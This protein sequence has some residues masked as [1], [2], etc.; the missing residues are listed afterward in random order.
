M[1]KLRKWSWTN[2]QKVRSHFIYYFLFLIFEIL[3]KPVSKYAAV[4]LPAEE[5]ANPVHSPKWIPDDENDDDD[6]LAYDIQEAPPQPKKLKK[7]NKP[8]KKKVKAEGE[9]RQPLMIISNQLIF[10]FEFY[11]LQRCPRT[12]RKM[13]P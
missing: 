12:V 8:N 7:G 4:L 1:K 2:W 10:Y 11:F 6:E 13:R 3:V 9:Y 5:I